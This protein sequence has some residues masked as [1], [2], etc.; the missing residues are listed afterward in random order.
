MKIKFFY[1][2][3]GKTIPVSPS[4]HFSTFI[5]VCIVSEEIK[6]HNPKPPVFLK[7]SSCFSKPSLHA[8][9]TPASVEEPVS[10]VHEAQ[11]FNCVLRG[12]RILLR[13]ISSVTLKRVPVP[14][15]VV[16]VDASG[17]MTYNGTARVPQARLCAKT[18]EA[19]SPVCS[20]TKF[21]KIWEVVPNADSFFIGNDVGTAFVAAGN[22]LAASY[23]HIA[24]LQTGSGSHFP[25]VNAVF[26]T[27]CE[28]VGDR[29]AARKVFEA[30]P[31]TG[32]VIF[33]GIG[34]Q[35]TISSLMAVAPERCEGQVFYIKVPE[36]TLG[37]ALDK[38]GVF[39]E[40]IVEALLS[41]PISFVIRD[42][43]GR[44]TRSV[45]AR[46]LKG[47][48]YLFPAGVQLNDVFLYGKPLS[49]VA[50]AVVTEEDDATM[51]VQQLQ[52]YSA[53]ATLNIV[54]AYN[55]ALAKLEL[56]PH[57][58]VKVMSHVIDLATRELSFISD[59]RR[60]VSE[61]RISRA[62]I[63]RART[64]IKAVASGAACS[65]SNADL[66]RTVRRMRD[67]SGS[68]MSAADEIVDI[69]RTLRNRICEPPS[70]A[71]LILANNLLDALGSGN[72]GSSKVARLLGKTA[73][74]QDAGLYASVA[75]DLQVYEDAMEARAADAPSEELAFSKTYASPEADLLD[76]MVATAPARC[77]ATFE[78]VGCMVA[79][80]SLK[81]VLAGSMNPLLTR[82]L[83]ASREPYKI[84]AVRLC[85]DDGFRASAG[86]ANGIIGVFPGDS[87]G[88][89]IAF[90]LISSYMAT[91]DW[92]TDIHGLRPL[93]A[94]LSG[95]VYLFTQ[96]QTSSVVEFAETLTHGF[97]GVAARI[98]CRVLGPDGTADLTTPVVSGLTAC[99]DLL[100]RA[101]SAPHLYAGNAIMGADY[102]TALE[103]AMRYAAP[104]LGENYIVPDRPADFTAAVVASGI[105]R[106]ATFFITP[107]ANTD[108]RLAFDMQKR[109]IDQFVKLLPLYIGK[110]EVSNTEEDTEDDIR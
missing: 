45:D 16:A 38:L 8:D 7:M 28:G 85:G 66:R 93:L 19:A 43:H 37:T 80:G 24:L 51:T 91:G 92:N 39:P 102:W 31:L 36:S 72:M 21:G 68:S 35:H 96:L 13:A 12:N 97:L 42:V 71:S 70:A 6:V 26:I 89:A 58:R 50:E 67:P 32:T 10:H 73:Q 109:A 55:F 40:S 101:F 62:E 52:Q 103:F 76:S 74:R 3:F 69:L 2:F 29:L 9:S 34:D 65:T 63:E 106:F 23:Q 104:R 107:A 30:L 20:I 82:V 105:S 22:G 88:A 84:Q 4:S 11:A 48:D 81:R 61:E 56:E 98:K 60:R 57:S 15:A 14:A 5:Y 54:R 27:D 87:V 79:V 47:A 95:V 100:L 90:K 1:Y 49:T 94:L 75:N 83:G 108:D 46:V 53:A 25:P 59:L 77:T 41:V 44:V 17:S 64:A 86:F 18:V 110:L 78:T 33:I 99:R